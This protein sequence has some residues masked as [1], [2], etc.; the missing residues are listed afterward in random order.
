MEGRPRGEQT[1]KK[2][3]GPIFITTQEHVWTNILNV[4]KSDS[5]QTEYILDY[6]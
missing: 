2:D 6:D 3:N 5:G 1:D 4:P